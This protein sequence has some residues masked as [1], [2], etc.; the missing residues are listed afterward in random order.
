[1][2]NLP[3]HLVQSGM[4]SDVFQTVMRFAIVARACVRLR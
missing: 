3:N 2:V 4:R 1:M